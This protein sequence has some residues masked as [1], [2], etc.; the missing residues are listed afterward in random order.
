MS[1]R[2]FM[3]ADAAQ[4]RFELFHI[5]ARIYFCLFAKAADYWV[6]GHQVALVNW[7]TA[8]W[9][10]ICRWRSIAFA[11]IAVCSPDCCVLLH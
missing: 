1:A 4:I 7:H 5:Q 11:I 8:G 2:S 10:H 9:L 6:C 3:H